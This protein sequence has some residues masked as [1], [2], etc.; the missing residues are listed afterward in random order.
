MIQQDRIKLNE[1]FIKVFSLLQDR[2]LIVLNDRDGR[3]MGDFADKILGNRQYGHIVRAF[4]NA[5]DKRVIDYHHIDTLCAAY[6]VN[7][8]FMLEGKGTP[9]GFD[10]PE[11]DTKLDQGVFRQ[12]ILFTT[13]QAF[14]GS[15]TGSEGFSKEDNEFFAIPGMA[16]GDFVAFPINGNS[17]EPVIFS[18]DMVICKKIDGVDIRDNEIY[19]VKHSGSLWIKYVQ[20]IYNSKRTRISKL[21]LISANNLEHDPFEID[22]DEHTQLFK[23]IKKITNM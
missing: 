10:L 17:M 19:A 15:T 18:G 3:G 13:T 23:V 22:V 7:K 14:A 9:F 20:R 6:G 1:R 5:K 4:L 12:N 11:P 16:G 8:K 21:K 2:G